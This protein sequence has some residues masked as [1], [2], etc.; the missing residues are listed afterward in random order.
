MTLND[1]LPVNLTG[2][3]AGLDYKRLTEI[4]LRSGQPLSVNYCG[5]M[6]FLGEK[7]ITSSD[8]A[9]FISQAIVSDVFVKACKNS[10][11]AYD[12]QV[13]QGYINLGE[14]VRIGVVGETV[15]NGAGGGALRRVHSL[16][17][18]LP[19]NVAGCSAEA[20][21]ELLKGGS[22]LV[23]APCGCG[24]T[25]F[26]KD[27]AVFL[28]KK[29]FNV[30]VIDERGELCAIGQRNAVGCDIA[31]NCP[32]KFVFENVIRSISP[33]VVVTD[34]LF[35]SDM[36]YVKL[37]ILSGTRVMASV[38]GESIRDAREKLGKE[39]ELFDIFVTL[40]RD[41]RV[42]SIKRKIDNKTA[43]QSI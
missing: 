13:M 38:H 29:G 14:G 5:E 27:I 31:S 28:G 32:K 30:T 2:A 7:G 33:D 36:E 18:R 24:K 15:R 20:W 9:F 4:R 42:V 17:I 43:G 3:I 10:V 34:E 22:M 1:I 21:K 35:A 37:C 16:C 12:E 6:H 41:R 11:Y 40:G 23:I 26:L 8:K 25:T 19:H 39:T